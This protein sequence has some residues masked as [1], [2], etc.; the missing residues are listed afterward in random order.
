[1]FISPKIIPALREAG[2]NAEHVDEES[3]GFRNKT[4]RK[5]FIENVTTDKRIK[6]AL[7]EWDAIPSEKKILLKKIRLELK[8]IEIL[9]FCL[10][11]RVFLNRKICSESDL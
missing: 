9:Q 5:L 1:M 2:L 8:L 7:E 10:L 11:G 4:I 6:A 3:V